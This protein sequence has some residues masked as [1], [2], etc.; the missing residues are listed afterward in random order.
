[1]STPFCMKKFCSLLQDY[2]FRAPCSFFIFSLAP[3]GLRG[4]A[5]CSGITPNG[6]LVHL[7]PTKKI[8]PFP[9][10]RPTHV[11]N[12]QLKKIFQASW[13]KHTFQINFP[14]FTAIFSIFLSI[15]L[16]TILYFFHE[17]IHMEA[18]LLST[19]PDFMIFCITCDCKSV[20]MCSILK[21]IC[22][23]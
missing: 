9:V 22:S 15:F 12:P 21:I 11:K 18:D 20:E 3:F 17:L 1:M 19:L 16:L 14:K 13:T 10:T 2:S 23:K 8:L 5:H 4:H 6:G 7:R